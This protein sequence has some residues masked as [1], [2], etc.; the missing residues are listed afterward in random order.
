[1]PSRRSTR[2]RV[3]GGDAAANAQMAEAKLKLS[4]QIAIETDPQKKKMMQAQYNAMNG[5]MG[6]AQAFGAKPANAAPAAKPST[7][8]F[9]WGFLGLGGKRSRRNKRYSRRR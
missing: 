3:R 7:G 4:A 2:R 8:L 9:G 6:F 5:M 1:M